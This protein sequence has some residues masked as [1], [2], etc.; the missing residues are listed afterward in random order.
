MRHHKGVTGTMSTA[1]I[2]DHLEITDLVNRLV[3]LLDS[4]DW[5]GLQDIFADTVY[6]DRTSLTGGDPETLAKPEFIGGWQYIMTGF[7]T[8]HHLVTGHVIHV[9]GDKATCNANMQGTHILANDTG[10]G[11]TWAVGGRHE[12]QAIRTA[13]GWRISGIIFTIQWA[14]GNQGIVDLSIAKGQAG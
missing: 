7:D 4:R 10:D 3:L 9:D 14:T 13:G 1:E 12:Y 5:A 8:V 6:N 11:D 2:V